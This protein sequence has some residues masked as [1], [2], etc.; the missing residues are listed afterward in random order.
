MK[1]RTKIVYYLPEFKEI[2]Y[3]MEIHASFAEK[4]I[5]L[6]SR[7]DAISFQNNIY[8][9]AKIY[10]AE[11][12]ADVK[13]SA[14]LVLYR[15][16]FES[17]VVDHYLTLEGTFIYVLFFETGTN[18]DLLHFRSDECGYWGEIVWVSRGRFIGGNTVLRVF[19]VFEASLGVFLVYVFDDARIKLDVHGGGDKRGGRTFSRDL[20]L[21]S[22]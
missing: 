15:S 14:F 9:S 8:H 17:N 4:L 22:F 11:N 21:R 12:S 6:K 5:F 18:T 3:S 19:G 13:N 1:L 20:P 7:L 10:F 2:C 16:D